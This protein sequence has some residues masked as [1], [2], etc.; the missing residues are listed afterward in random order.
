MIFI[1]ICY[2]ISVYI[3][4]YIL[5]KLNNKCKFNL[6][7]SLLAGISGFWIVFIPLCLLVFPLYYIG[8]KFDKK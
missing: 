3:I 8:S 4:F 1:I 7:L 5:C 6:D 2:I